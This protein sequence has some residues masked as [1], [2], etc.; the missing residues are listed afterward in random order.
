MLVHVHAHLRVHALGGAAQRELAQSD[1]VALAEEVLDGLL[2]L[3]GHVHLAVLE[4]LEELV[5]RQID[6]LDLVGLLEYRIRHGLADH[7]PG[8][9][10][11]DVVEGLEVLHVHGRVDVDAGV[12]K[13]D[14]VLPALG[15]SEAGGVRVRELVDE[16]QGGT[17]R[18]RGVEVE[19]AQRGSAVID[20]PRRKDLEPL[21]QRVGLG[22]AVSLDAPDEHVDPVGLLLAHGLQHRVGLADPGGGAE[23]YLQLSPMVTRFLRLDTGQERLGIRPVVAHGPSVAPTPRRDSR[24]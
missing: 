19:L 3:L 14:D 10:R 11:D 18:E 12:E 16:D 24:L 1:Q 5:G 9:L 6:Q 17:A 20:H 23:E 7:D 22:P 2:S 15:V 4:A 13:L 8:D 21:E